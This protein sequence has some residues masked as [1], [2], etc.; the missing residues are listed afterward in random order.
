MASWGDLNQP[1][2]NEA[3][4]RQAIV[5]LCEVHNRRLSDSG[6]LHWV[7]RLLPYSKGSALWRALEVACDE[8]TFPSIGWVL[9]QITIEQRKDTKPYIPPPQ[10]TEVEQ[11]NAELARVKAIAWLYHI[12][13]WK[14]DDFAGSVF[15]TGDE[16]K[17]IAQAIDE[18][19]ARY[20]RDVV[21]RWMEDSHAAGG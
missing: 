9:E 11:H 18:I 2:P 4:L 16:G 13:G 12:A 3:R 20:H 6:F 8:R 5:M 10:L 19:A 1:D 15:F 21:A 14:A 17:P 7:K